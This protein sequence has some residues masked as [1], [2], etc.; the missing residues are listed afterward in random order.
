MSG[1]PQLNGLEVRRARTSDVSAIK[2]LI[3]RQPSLARQVIDGDKVID[4]EENH[5]EEECLK[6]LALHQPVAKDLRRITAALKINAELDKHT[7]IA[8]AFR[9]GNLG[10]M[11][12]YKLRNVQADTSMREAIA[13]PAD[14]AKA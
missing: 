2:A 8:D 1:A 13:K 6:L 4:A 9:S 7:A 10:V 3:D 14:G 5:I 12:Y 11:D